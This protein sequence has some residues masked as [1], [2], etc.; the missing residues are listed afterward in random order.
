MW[1]AAPSELTWGVIYAVITE[2]GSMV[3]CAN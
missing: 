3:R 2:A 1:L